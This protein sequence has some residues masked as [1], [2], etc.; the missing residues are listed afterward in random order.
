MPYNFLT[1]RRPSLVKVRSNTNTESG[2]STTFPPR[3][4]ST[5]ISGVPTALTF[6]RIIDGATC[7]VGFHIRPSLHQPVRH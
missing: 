3:E 6:D 7:P 4:T 2:T 1:Y 5:N